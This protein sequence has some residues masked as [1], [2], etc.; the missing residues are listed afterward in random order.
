MN[1]VHARNGRL[2][3]TVGMI[4]ALL[5]FGSQ[6]NEKEQSMVDAWL[7]QKQLET[8]LVGMAGVVF[9]AGEVRYLA[10]AGERKKGSGVAVTVDDRWHIG[11]ITKS[12]TATLLAV[13]VEAGEL[14]WD[15]P[16]LPL[17]DMAEAAHPDWQG[18]TLAQ[19][20]S[21]TSG[22]PANFSMMLNLR[23]SPEET[24]RPDARRQAV[25]R[26]L[27]KPPKHSPGT[28]FV[29]SNVGYTLAGVVIE[30]LT[31]QSWEQAMRERLFEPLALGSAGFGPPRSE[32][33]ELTE[34][35]GHQHL[36]GFT[37]AVSE[38]ADNTAIM[39]P[40]GTVHMGLVDLARYGYEHLAGERGEG[41]LLNAESYQSLHRPNMENYAYGWVLRDDKPEAGPMLWHNGSNTFWYGLL[42]LVP[43][44]DAVVAMVFNDGN[45]GKADPVAWQWVE[46]SLLWLAE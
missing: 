30:T 11:S 12:M 28:T 3:P 24:E 18:L 16:L 20:L 13:L 44:Q 17:L 34:P 5:S 23:S 35:R 2:I 4:L 15:A 37:R 29:Y 31:G 14:D 6:A 39:G 27:E 46:Q 8:G 38:T 10:A 26:V 22:L 25:L 33:D 9:Q 21:H 42:V 36:L 7:Q 43:E 40:A 45:I 41:T 19:V 32:G 1:K